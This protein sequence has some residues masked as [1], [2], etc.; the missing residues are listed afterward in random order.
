MLLEFVEAKMLMKAPEFI[1]IPDQ[2]HA[3]YA[4]QVNRVHVPSLPFIL[5]FSL[6]SRLCAEDKVSLETILKLH[7]FL[8]LSKSKEQIGVR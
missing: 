4:E 6:H 7:I 3:A 5:S 2:M 8:H 1:F